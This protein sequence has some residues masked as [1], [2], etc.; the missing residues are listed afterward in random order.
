M[1]WV[2][3]VIVI[4]TQFYVAPHAFNANNIKYCG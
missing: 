1:S 4:I 2:H 3:N